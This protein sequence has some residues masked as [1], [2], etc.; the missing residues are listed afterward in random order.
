MNRDVLK[1]CC[2]RS[3]FSSLQLEI[4]LMKHQRNNLK[5]SSLK[6]DQ[7]SALGQFFYYKYLNRW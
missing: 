1:S 7:L 2:V 5:R 3:P 4:F 6:L